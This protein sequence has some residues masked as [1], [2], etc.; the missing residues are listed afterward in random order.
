MHDKVKSEPT[1]VAIGSALYNTNLSPEL[2]SGCFAVSDKGDKAEKVVGARLN[3]KGVQPRGGYV[4]R[5]VSWQ[6]LIVHPSAI[7]L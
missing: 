7:L 4:V 1:K 2:E 5:L 6:N 3:R